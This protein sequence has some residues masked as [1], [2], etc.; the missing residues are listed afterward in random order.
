IADAATADGLVWTD[1]SD[2]GGLGVLLDAHPNLGWMQRP[3][4]GIERYVEVGSAHAD[5]TWTCGKGVYAEHVA[6]HALAL[7]LAGLRHLGSY[8]RA[9]RW[10]RS[11]G[12]NLLG[13]R[14]VILGGGGITESLLRLLGPFGCD[15]T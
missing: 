11:R 5:R 6:E 9:E 1:P 13:A 8:A 15:V 3:C 10:G 14:V 2:P 12:V 7:A 4:A